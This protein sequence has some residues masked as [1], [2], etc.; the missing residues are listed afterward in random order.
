MIRPVQQLSPA[1]DEIPFGGV[2]PTRPTEFV[3]DLHLDPRMQ[4]ESIADLAE[5]LPQSV[6]YDTAAQPLLVPEVGPPRGSWS[7]LET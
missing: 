2:F 4:L 7:G 1:L 5:R 6:I 3:H